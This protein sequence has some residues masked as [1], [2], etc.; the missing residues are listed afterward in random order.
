MGA[1]ERIP[2]SGAPY[3]GW[4]IMTSSRGS[5]LQRAGGER[6]GRAVGGGLTEADGGAGVEAAEVRGRLVRGTRGCQLSEMLH[7][8]SLFVR[9]GG[10][11][12]PARASGREHRRICQAH[13]NAR[14]IR[15]LRV[16]GSALRLPATIYAHL[17][18]HTSPQ[19]AFAIFPFVCTLKV[20]ARE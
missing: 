6:R 20:R 15:A 16:S 14:W 4:L 5:D 3:H 11:L 13:E 2:L 18:K 1:P 8:L 12:V 9:H 17:D 10:V 19:A 7:G